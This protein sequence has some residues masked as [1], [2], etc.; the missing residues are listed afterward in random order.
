MIPSISY[1]LIF[2]VLEDVFPDHAYLI[3]KCITRLV[4]IRTDNPMLSTMGITRE[5]TLFVNET[6][7]EKHI[8]SKD[9]L[10]TV[11][12][13]ELEHSIS[14]DINSLLEYN[15]DPEAEIKNMANNIAM[16]SRINAHIIN[17]FTF[18]S[19]DFF[20]SFYNDELCD[21]DVLNK[22]LR[23]NSKFGNTEE[24]KLIKPFY[25]QFYKEKDLCDHSGLYEVVLD[26]LKKRE[27]GKK[28]IYVKLIGAHGAGG[29][30]LTEKDLEGAE[31][32]EIHVDELKKAQQDKMNNV[33]KPDTPAGGIKD[34]V[35]DY[36]SE[37]SSHEAGHGSTIT[38]SMLNSSLR[39]TEKFD[40]AKFKH[41]AFNEIFHN[42]RK[43]A[44]VKIGKY[45]Q[46]PLIPKR[47][48]TSDYL[49]VGMDFPP[50][51][52][53]SPK[54]VFKTDKALLPIYLD[55]SGST[56]PYLPEIIQ[57]LA[58]ISNEL[59]YVWGFSDLIHKHTKEDLQQNRIHSTGGTDFNCVV[60]HA[61]EN[62]YKHIVVL[63]D[64]YASCRFQGR[65]P[66]IQSVVTILFGPNNKENYF[67]K[68]YNNTF[69]IEEVKL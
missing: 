40:L 64:G 48:T 2:D 19:T 15:K 5:G 41:L 18:N 26:I 39:I 65:I 42:I 58:N 32:I 17:A 3:L 38:T 60:D 11:L 37:I 35:I 10:K 24:E 54:Y 25:D 50:V 30:E 69:D 53:K 27:A 43:Q 14:G 31:V 13:H 44:R 6:F 9:R 49:R 28:K 68:V 46:S 62:N 20:T 7:W 67:S 61:I 66:S 21:K 63:T 1:G 29:K 57:L 52:Y 23:P 36:L 33:P 55:V 8:T 51:M 22:L 34:A 56:T 59:D 16:D 45:T 47:L 12:T 4:T